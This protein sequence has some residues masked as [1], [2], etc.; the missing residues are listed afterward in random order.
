MRRPLTLLAG[1]AL[2]LGLIAPAAFGQTSGS[3][4]PPQKKKA[5]KVWTNDDFAGH[6]PEPAT[7]EKEKTPEAAKPSA[8]AE[9]EA[10]LQ[11]L[12]EERQG[13]QD[14]VDQGPKQ[15]QVFQDKI[16]ASSDPREQEAYRDT[17]A[18]IEKAIARSQKNIQ[19]LDAKI[20]DLEKQLKAAQ[21]RESKT[22]K[23]PAAPPST[24]APSTPPSS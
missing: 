20:A 13:D 22:K 17:I 2:L 18:A 19:E 9:L 6:A 24:P 21:R 1:L 3:Q 11:Q 10:R 5:T 14:V 23:K 12:R 16:N 7:E 15:I 4:P 8:V